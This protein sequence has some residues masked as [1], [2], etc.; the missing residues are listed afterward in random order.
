M[1]FLYGAS[2]AGEPFAPKPQPSTPACKPGLSEA[3]MRDMIRKMRAFADELEASLVVD[4]E[5]RNKPVT[6]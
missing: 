6:L 5:D 2:F 3:D 4:A 1:R